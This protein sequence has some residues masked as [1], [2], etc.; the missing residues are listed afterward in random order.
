MV[1]VNACVL[2]RALPG[3]V[4]NVAK[5]ADG[6]ANVRK[7]M[8]TYGRYDIVAMVEAPS[9]EAASKTVLDINALSG[10]KSTESLLEV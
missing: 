2:I 5:A 4:E 9:V 6:I 7:T 1:V 8:L 3:Q 10:V